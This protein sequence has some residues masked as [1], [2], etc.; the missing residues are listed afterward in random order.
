M[1]GSGPIA[2]IHVSWQTRLIK[3]ISTPPALYWLLLGLPRF[4]FR[5]C[6][7]GKVLL[8]FLVLSSVT[9]VDYCYCSVELY[10]DVDPFLSS[11]V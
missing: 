2:M 8:L 6:C 4:S 5:L 7:G 3:I 1:T 10:T 11:R 9:A